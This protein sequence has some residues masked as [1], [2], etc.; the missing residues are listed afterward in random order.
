MK[1]LYYTIA[2]LL[3][4]SACS[5]LNK[6]SLYNLSKQY[7]NTEFT[8]L[9]AVA[10][11]DGRESARIYVPVLMGDMVTVNDE[12]NGKN[13]RKAQIQ[14]ELFETYESKVILDSTTII[15]VDS[16]LITDDTIISFDILYP[17]QKRYILK[18]ELTDLNRV[19]AVRTFL[20]LDNSSPYSAENYLLKDDENEI[21]FN[22]VLSEEDDIMLQ[23]SDTVASKMF[24]R[25]YNRNYPLALPPFLEETESNF[26]YNADSI[27]VVETHK[28]F[29]SIFQL[30]DQGF[31]HFQT[32]SNHR[33]WNHAVQFCTLDSHRSLLR[34]KCCSH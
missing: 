22:H 34:S 3:L 33:G 32:D 14:Y 4:L 27:L 30:S 25:Y 12:E 1:R 17:E 28:G 31:Y 19:D 9:H 20:D 10:F 7:S 18:L 11:N 5:S 15:L 2:L 16:T 24:V 8:P 13:Y 26:D 21:V 29:S 23:L 6:L